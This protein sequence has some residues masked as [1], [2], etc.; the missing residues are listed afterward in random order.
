MVPV[1]G[2]R[3]GRRV[4]VKNRPGPGDE[5]VPIHRGL[6]DLHSDAGGV[7]HDKAAVFNVQRLGQDFVRDRK[8]VHSGPAVVRV[9][10]VLEPF[11]HGLGPADS[12][13]RGG[14]HLQKRAPAV[15][16]ETD[17]LP[18]SGGEHPLPHRESALAADVHLNEVDAFGL[19]EVAER[20]LVRLVLS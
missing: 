5:R 11:D 4:D 3:L 17:S 19:D 8:R 12:E 1:H 2:E 7:G 18:L 20:G 9:Q 14:N 10:R 15:E 6:V 16:R 13:L